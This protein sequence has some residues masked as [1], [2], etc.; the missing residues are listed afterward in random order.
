MKLAAIAFAA[1]GLAAAAGSAAASSRVTDVDYMRAS[2]CKG[3]A[4]ALGSD[5]AGFDAFLKAEGRSRDVSILDRAADEMQ[6]AKREARDANMKER[7][8]AELNGPCM[9]YLNGGGSAATAR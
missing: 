5:T 6:R 1:L 9:A 7:L 3:L 2:R 4:V 8:T